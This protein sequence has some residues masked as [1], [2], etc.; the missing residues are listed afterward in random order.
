MMVATGSEFNCW[1]WKRTRIPEWEDHQLDKEG[2]KEVL[3][4]R[5]G[6]AHVV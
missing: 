1:F 4:Y 5:V 2:V 3:L 6:V